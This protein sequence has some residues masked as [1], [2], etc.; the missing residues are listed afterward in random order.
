MSGEQ[1]V[2][3][4]NWSPDFKSKPGNDIQR[5]LDQGVLKIE[6]HYQFDK[7]VSFDIV[8]G[9]PDPQEEK[10]DLRAK[11]VEPEWV[12]LLGHNAIGVEVQFTYVNW[13]GKTS[14]RKAVFS[15]LQF[16]K[17]EYHPEP[18]LLLYGYDLDKKAPRT[19][20]VKDITNL[21]LL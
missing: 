4:V 15:L 8:A 10:P 19:Y 21:K 17:N 11:P 3:H 9:D 16:G 2:G 13:K 20:A 18:Q 1:V 14:V 5:L 7:L 6:A 12:T